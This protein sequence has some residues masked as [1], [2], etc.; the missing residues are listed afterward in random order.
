MTWGFPDD[1]T[2]RFDTINWGLKSLSSKRFIESLPTHTKVSHEEKNTSPKDLLHFN[3]SE[4]KYD[5][6]IV[7]G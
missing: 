1:Y 3:F 5:K 2:V 4:I 6:V 7:H